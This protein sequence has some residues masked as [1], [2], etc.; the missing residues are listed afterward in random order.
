MTKKEI[1]R[2]I[3]KLRAEVEKPEPDLSDVMD[4]L[5]GIEDRLRRVEFQRAQREVIHIAPRPYY[6]WYSHPPVIYSTT[7]QPNAMF[8]NGTVHNQTM[9]AALNA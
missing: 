6:P 4:K 9:Q 2:T 7:T 8:H 1:L 3:D 5:E